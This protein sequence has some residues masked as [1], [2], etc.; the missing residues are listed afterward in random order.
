ML[1][2]LDRQ[3]LGLGYAPAG[4]HDLP[5]LTPAVSPP[6]LRATTTYRRIPSRGCQRSRLPRGHGSNNDLRP[7]DQDLGAVLML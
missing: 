4:G 7:V 6:K 2:P 1:L 3:D 5:V